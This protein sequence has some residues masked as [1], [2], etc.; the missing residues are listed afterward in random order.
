M[1][2]DMGLSVE[3][4]SLGQPSLLR[5]LLQQKMKQF[6]RV[7]LVAVKWVRF[8]FGHTWPSL[9]Q[10]PLLTKKE[11]R[12]IGRGEVEMGQAGRKMHEDPRGQLLWKQA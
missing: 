6:Y 3:K 4:D 12:M 9:L 7:L 2:V 5:L 11:L 1:N 8:D 10:L